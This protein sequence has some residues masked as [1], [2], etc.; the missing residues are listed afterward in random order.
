MTTAKQR[1]PVM[2]DVA[3][4][5]GVSHQTVSRVLNAH[6]NVT[7]ATRGRV[8][9]A[10]RQLGYRRNTAARA[11]VTRRSRTLGVVSSGTGHYG[12]ANTLTGIARAAREADHFVSFV[13]LDQVDQ[14][15]M[16]AALDHLRGSGVDGI[17]VL[18]PTRA[19][20]EA[21]SGLSA[22]VPVVVVDGQSTQRNARVAI[23]QVHGGRQATAHLLGLGHRTVHHVH[24]PEGW[25]EAEARADGWRAEL[26]AAGAVVPPCLAGDWTAASG[27]DAGRRLAADPEVTAVF[28]A[29]DQ[30]ALGVLLAL[31]EAGRR[32][33][34]QVSV[35]GFDDIPEAGYLMPPLTTVRQDFEELGRRCLGQLRALL[36]DSPPPPDTLIAPELVVRRS[37]AGAPRG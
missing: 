20:L 29:N 32:V 25:L 3:R 23:D 36:G 16:Q 28:A 19:A 10:I 17:V 12:P 37:T 33:P 4:L 18:S 15:S 26:R 9:Q 24:G 2:A 13:D 1:T 22:D 30:M 35:V 21:V 14:V 11:L 27:Y 5:A 7:P 8:E 6:P 34:E 31:H